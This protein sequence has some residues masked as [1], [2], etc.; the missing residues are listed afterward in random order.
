M[1]DI[2]VDDPDGVRADGAIDPAFE[3]AAEF[4]VF[5]F[6]VGVKIAQRLA[7][8]FGKGGGEKRLA[9]NVLAVHRHA[10]ADV[11]VQRPDQSGELDARL[12]V[13]PA[14]RAVA[15]EIDQANLV[16]VAAR[17]VAE[18]DRSLGGADGVGELVEDDGVLQ[19]EA[20]GVVDDPLSALAYRQ[21]LVGP[22]QAGQDRQA[23]RVRRGPA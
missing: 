21:A 7:N 5:A 18:D 4:R 12:L 16:H 19:G 1:A 11:R 20:D 17:L 14:E 2:G 9:V 8:L 13:R 6:A 22:H 23:G 3:S 15:L 10:Y